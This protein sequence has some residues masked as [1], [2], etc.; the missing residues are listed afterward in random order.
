MSAAQVFRKHCE[1]RRNCSS[2]AVSPFPT[3]FSTH[4]EK[5]LPFLPNS[6]LS[7][8]N[9]KSLKFV[10]WERVNP[11]TIILS[12][13]T[14]LRASLIFCCLL[15]F[16]ITS[17]A[18]PKINPKIYMCDFFSP[19]PNKPWF[20][21]VCSTSVWKHCGKRRNC[22]FS[23]LLEKFLPFSLNL[24]L[25]SANSYT[26]GGSEICCLGKGYFFVVCW[27]PA[28]SPFPTMF[29]KGFSLTGFKCHNWLTLSQTSPGFYVSALQVF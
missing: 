11:H 20:L 10:L 28:M 25:L 14:A 19:F 26:L 4:L 8:A 23:S 18:C 13:A 1:Q 16:S 9:W 24:K 27:L 29:Y 22:L 17:P 15:E 5:F 3:V 7:S 12:T 2:Q 6:K 21:C